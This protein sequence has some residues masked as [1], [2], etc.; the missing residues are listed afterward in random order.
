MEFKQDLTGRKFERWTVLFLINER[1][2]GGKVWK[3]VCYGSEE[4]PHEPRFKSIRSDILKSGGSKS[5][6]CY[7]IDNMGLR[8]QNFKTHGRSNTREYTSYRHAKER[9]LDPNC[10]DFHNYGARGIKFLF[11]SF[12]EFYKEIGPIPSD[13]YLLD[14]TDNSGH[15]ERGNIR[16]ATREQQNQ[17][18]RFN[19][20]YPEAVRDIRNNASANTVEHYMRKYNCGKST[21][22]D[23]FY[24][25]TWK[26]IK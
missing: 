18:R 11:A 8:G 5:C 16:W 14:R 23:A 24:Y 9:C 20:L 17:N 1:K 6:G 15:Y 25:K 10:A 13:K 3:C 12:D 4:N 22:F 19:K 7:N 21:I 26:N 2:N